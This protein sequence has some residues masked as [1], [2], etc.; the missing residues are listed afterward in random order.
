[1]A[2]KKPQRSW[3]YLERDPHQSVSE[4]IMNDNPIQSNLPEFG[5]SSM[6]SERLYQHPVPTVKP[7]WFS[8]F[9]ALLLLVVLFGG[10]AL[11]FV[12]QA[13]KEAAYQAEAI[14]RA[15]EDKR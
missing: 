9:S 1:M 14:A 15:L 3:N 7:H 2:N 4:I 13:D 10:L 12:H 5:Q 11:M 8:N 6:T